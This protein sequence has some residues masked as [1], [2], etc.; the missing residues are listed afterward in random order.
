MEYTQSSMRQGSIARC[1]LGVAPCHTEFVSGRAL[2][3][4]RRRKPHG[5][6]PQVESNCGKT[7]GRSTAEILAL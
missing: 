5:K 2:N 4:V 3:M 1:K 7:A 6:V